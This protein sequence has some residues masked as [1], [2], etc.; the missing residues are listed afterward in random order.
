MDEEE[1]HRCLQR[2]TPARTSDKL[3]GTLAE[4]VVMNDKASASLKSVQYEP[5]PPNQKPFPVLVSLEI[6]KIKTHMVLKAQEVKVNGI[7]KLNNDHISINME[8]LIRGT[9][10]ETTTTSGNNLFRATE[11][12]GNNSTAAQQEDSRQSE[13]DKEVVESGWRIYLAIFP[14]SLAISSTFLLVVLIIKGPALLVKI[15]KGITLA[16]VVTA[17]GLL[18]HAL[19]PEHIYTVTFIIPAVIMGILFPVTLI[20]IG[21]LR[22]SSQQSE[23]DKEAIESGWKICLMNF[24]GSSGLILAIYHNVQDDYIKTSIA[25]II[26]AFILSA[27]GTGD[28]TLLGHKAVM[29]RGVE[30]LQMDPFGFIGFIAPETRPPPV[31]HH[32]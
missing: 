25:L 23:S 18:A 30:D 21:T 31:L 5:M 12:E 29:F 16:M 17:V 6:A 20:C 26:V 14:L 27:N 9:Q 22:G 15:F 8:S 10:R 11:A 28:D 1:L 19:L 4:E 24:V 32:H 2:D 7:E 13:N 3:N